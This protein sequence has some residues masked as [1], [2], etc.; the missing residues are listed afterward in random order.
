MIHSFY[1]PNLTN[2]RQTFKICKQ[3]KTH[4]YR[5]A[6]LPAARMDFTKYRLRAGE[7]KCPPH[8]SDFN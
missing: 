5:F 3:V 6:A 1:L 2:E 7:F 8:S 4:P